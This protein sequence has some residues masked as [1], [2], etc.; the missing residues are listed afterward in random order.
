MHASYPKH[1]KHL[2][3]TIALPDRGTA[4]PRVWAAHSS[5]HM[6]QRKAAIA[7]RE[8]A[9]PVR[10]CL[11]SYLRRNHAAIPYAVLHRTLVHASVPAA[12]ADFRAL[13]QHPIYAASR[14]SQQAI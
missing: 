8:G 6:L 3:H 7:R 2:L 10:L 14:R 12:T 13:H 1:A 11:G 5:Q 4:K 9:S